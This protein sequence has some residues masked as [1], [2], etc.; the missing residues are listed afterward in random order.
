MTRPKITAQKREILG[1]KVKKL[2]R[3]GILPANIYGK[4]VKSVGIQVNLKDFVDIYK[5]VGETGLVDLQIEGEKETRPVLIHNVCKHPVEDNFLHADF[6]QII[7]T[8]K[9]KATIPVELI[10]EAPAVAQN[11]GVLVQISKEIEVEALPTDLPEHFQVDIS[12]L[13]KVDDVVS[14][15]DINVDKKKVE[16]KLGDEQ[17]IAKIEHLAKEEA[18]TPPPIA[19]V[20]A[21]GAPPA[22][23]AAP[24]EV[25]P[26]GAPKKEEKL[27]EKKTLQQG[28]GGELSRTALGKEEKKQ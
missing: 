14:V 5:E 18:V 8:E 1:K 28:F 23:G 13:E 26:T 27:P 17:I 16:L 7:L 6:R 3:E 10:G 15:K 9:V 19:E 22:E 12:K 2:R 24:A 21:E 20:P 4:K 11:L 25:K